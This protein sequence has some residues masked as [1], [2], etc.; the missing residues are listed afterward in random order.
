MN[1]GFLVAALV[2]LVLGLLASYVRAIETFK[3]LPA[4][5]CGRQGD[6]PCP[7]G[8]KCVGG[9]CAETE[10]KNL[11]EPEKVLAHEDDNVF[12]TAPSFCPDGTC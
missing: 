7:H 2:I 4:Q 11:P 10:E 12:G 3:N 1:T 9:F 5:S 6:G 8:T